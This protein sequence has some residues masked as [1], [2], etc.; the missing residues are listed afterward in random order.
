MIFIYRGPNSDSV[1]FER[2]VETSERTNLYDEVNLHYHVIGNLTRAVA[3]SFVCKASGKG[4]RRDI[5]H[6]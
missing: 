1:M 6:V 5:T 2:K 4:C 3:K